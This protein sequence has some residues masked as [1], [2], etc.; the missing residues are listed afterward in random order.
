MIQLDDTFLADLGLADLP[1]AER[2]SLLQNV[3]EE[4]EL[5]VGSALT[6]GLSDAQLTEFEAIIDK[7]YESIVIWLDLNVPDFINDGVYQ[8]MVQAL[9]DTAD[10]SDI[11]CE[12]ASTKWLEINRPDYQRVVAA[13]L[14]DI[15]EQ[16]RHDAARILGSV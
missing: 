6:D 5:R 11:V 14:D 9:A 13:V 1:A 2:Q 15:K 3:Y 8:K 4:L 10:Q 12:Y 7:D 16:I